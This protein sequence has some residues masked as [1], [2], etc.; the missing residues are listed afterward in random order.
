MHFIK[1][2][3]LF[4][5]KPTNDLC[6]FYCDY[7]IFFI[8]YYLC[9]LCKRI[10]THDKQNTIGLF[11]LLSISLEFQIQYFLFYIIMPNTITIII[12]NRSSCP[13]FQ[14]LLMTLSAEYAFGKLTNQIHQF[15]FVPIRLYLTASFI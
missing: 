7:V 1:S 4:L 12:V 8:F 14:Q 3:N 2:I 13:T 6:G 15:K 9:R 5:N 11:V 10:F